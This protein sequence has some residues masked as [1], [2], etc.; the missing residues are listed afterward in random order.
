MHLHLITCLFIA[1]K[2]EE[3]KQL[4]ADLVIQNIVKNKYTKEELLKT[5]LHILK[6]LNFVLPKNHFIDY[7]NIIF[8]DNFYTTNHLCLFSE[9]VYSSCINIY[10]VL[11]LDFFRIRYN[12]NLL[13][14]F[15]SVFVYSL[16]CVIKG[17]NF[18]HCFNA[19]LFYKGLSQFDV[20][21]EQVEENVRKISMKM[22]SFQNAKDN[23]PYLY[24]ELFGN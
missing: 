12:S 16:F 14:L 18:N 7:V 8:Y 10:K 6:K 15:S 9:I 11:L 13:L 4:K 23:Y 21:E 17:I 19:K 1:S 2:I 24:N 3:T 5:E 20:T 22:D